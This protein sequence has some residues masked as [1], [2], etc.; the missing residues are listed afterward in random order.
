MKAP[1]VHAPA[2]L[3]VSVRHALVACGLGES[4]ARALAARA[5]AEGRTRIEITVLGQSFVIERRRGNHAVLEV[6]G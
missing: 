2:R 4:E 6:V 5:M 1:G 3:Q